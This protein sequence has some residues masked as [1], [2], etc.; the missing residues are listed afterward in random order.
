VQRAAD[1]APAKPG[2]EELEKLTSLCGK[3]VGMSSRGQ[4]GWIEADA[5]DVTQ[6]FRELLERVRA[7]EEV[8]PDEA[9]DFV[10]LLAPAV[11]SAT[12]TPTT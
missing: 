1:P 6:Q 7:D 9:G 12:S 11:S 4:I 3:G 8:V 10:W 5:T 2:S